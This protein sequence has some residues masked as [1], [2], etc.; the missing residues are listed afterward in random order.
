MIYILFKRTKEQNELLV[1]KGGW[2]RG[3]AKGE[4]ERASEQRSKAMG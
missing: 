2:P 1:G 3:L 4:T